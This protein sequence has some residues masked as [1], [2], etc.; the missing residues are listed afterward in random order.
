MATHERQNIPYRDIRDMSSQLPPQYLAWVW[1]A[2]WFLAQWA[3][4]AGANP[5]ACAIN[6]SGCGW[7][8]LIPLNGSKAMPNPMDIAADTAGNLYLTGESHPDQVPGQSS[9]QL[10]KFDR[11]GNVIWSR[12]LRAQGKGFNTS[13][14]VKVGGDGSICLTGTTDGTFGNQPPRR[15]GGFVARFDTNG[16]RLWAMNSTN[17]LGLVD[18]DQA[19]N[20]YAAS[21]TEILKYNTLGQLQW[22]YSTAIYAMASTASGRVYLLGPGTTATT[23][24][25]TVLHENGSPLRQ[26][27]LE[28]G[29][30]IDW[31]RL[32]FRNLKLVTDH[33]E[34]GYLQGSVAGYDNRGNPLRNTYLAKHDVTGV[35]LWERYHGENGYGWDSLDMAVDK[36]GSAYLV[37][38]KAPIPNATSPYDIFTLKYSGDGTLQWAREFSTPATDVAGGIAVD[39]NGNYYIAGGTAGNLDG[40]VNP[41][42]ERATT[43]FIARNRPQ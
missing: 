6:D 18:I 20:C 34:N 14:G 13:Y 7:T 36:E 37:G 16:N 41:V 17:G 8:Q 33:Q 2:G 27:V 3:L 9:I 28:L 21:N 32:D 40:L 1:L 26:S 29:K 15:G 24:L 35:L 12:Y 23:W 42:A 5:D 39:S 22:Q 4:P 31:L 43:P 30:D 10:V 38:T 25:L 19:G 11:A